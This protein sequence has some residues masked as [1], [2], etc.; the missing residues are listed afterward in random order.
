MPSGMRSVM[1]AEHLPFL[2][3][4]AVLGRFV[5]SCPLRL[6]RSSQD[7]LPPARQFRRCT[8]SPPLVWDV[9]TEKLV[10]VSY[11]SRQ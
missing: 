3:R 9:R 10:L 4:P 8:T 7:S 11:E 1:C 5:H 2:E 6:L